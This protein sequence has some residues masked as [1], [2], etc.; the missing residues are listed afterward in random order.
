MKLKFVML[1]GILAMTGCAAMGATPGDSASCENLTCEAYCK[2]TS[3]EFAV[4]NVAVTAKWADSEKPIV[5]PC[6]CY[7]TE[8][9]L[10]PMIPLNPD[11]TAAGLTDP[12]AVPA[13]T[14]GPEVEP[15]K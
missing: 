10:K 6:W 5:A 4:E 3:R 8:K 9:D 7:A 1:M 14:P 11:G 2:N 12:N 13:A 15:A